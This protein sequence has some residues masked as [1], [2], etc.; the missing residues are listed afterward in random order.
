MGA[1]LQ[2]RNLVFSQQSKL[3]FDHLNLTVNDGDR[4]GLAGHNGS[5]KS[6]LFSLIARQLEPDEGE[7]VYPG[8]LQ[9]GLVEQFLPDRLRDESLESAVLAALTDEFPES[10][11]YRVQALLGDLGFAPQQQALPVGKL[12]GGQQNLALLARAMIAE[13]DLL[14]L[15]EPSNHMDVS[16][17]AHLKHYLLNQ[18]GISLLLI[19]HDRDLLDSCC[20]RTCFL[21]DQTIL[22]FDQPYEQARLALEEHDEQ[23]ARRRRDEEKELSRVRDS[24]KQLAQWGKT[25]DNEKLSRKAISMQRRAQKMEQNLTA[26]TRGSGLDL[27]FDG[28]HLN[29]KT[30]LTLEALGVDTPDGSR[31][32][33]SCDFLVARPGDRIALLGENGSGKTTTLERIMAEQRAPEMAAIRFN[34]NVNPV[35]YDQ[36]LRQFDES[37]GR[38]DWLRK[39]SD[40]S[41][42]AIKR[43]LIQS[44]VAYRDFGQA[45]RHLSGGEKAR[46]MFLLIRLRKPNLMILDEP[47]NHID[48]EGREQLEAQIIESGTTLIVTSHDR[49]FLENVANR[50]WLIRNGALL[51][52]QSLDAFYRGLETDAHRALTQM[53]ASGAPTDPPNQE[54]AILL[55]IDELESLLQA[56]RAR[57]PKFQKPARQREW[58]EE[59]DR[60]WQQLD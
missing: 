40:A 24:A 16:A 47:T 38:F 5:G 21:R 1:I 26:V 31:R 20:T 14:L 9:I 59:L 60:L 22:N 23:A 18:R 52:V 51:E 11:L 37:A 19:S 39:R 48:L 15:D 46:L 50:F 44:G 54:E 17:L 34:P 58:Q 29:S 25:F 6:T 7:I 36:E 10:Q 49:R 8:G 12:S 53:A 32:L 56:D 57:K 30:V 42:D 55:R 13:P 43:A 35:Y 33:L 27:G 28:A 41:D 2:L 45:V 4:I 3:L